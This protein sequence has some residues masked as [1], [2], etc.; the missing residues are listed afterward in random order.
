MNLLV[1]VLNY[2]M[3]QLN[4]KILSTQLINQIIRK[5]NSKQERWGWKA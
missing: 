5:L 4:N 2:M 3:N 1:V